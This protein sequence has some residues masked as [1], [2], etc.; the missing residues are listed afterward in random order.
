MTRERAEG[1]SYFEPALSEAGDTRPLV[2]IIDDDAQ[3]L[4]VT[5]FIL[6]RSGFRIETAESAGKGLEL[7]RELQPDVIVCDAGL[8]RINGC[9]LLPLLKHTNTTADIP[10]I[11]MSGSEGLDCEGMFTFLRKPFDTAAL[12]DATRNA[13]LLHAA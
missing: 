8:P 12:V 4:H 13:L 2:L 3:V 11:L 6:Q 10:V 7:A 1:E 9:P 5:K